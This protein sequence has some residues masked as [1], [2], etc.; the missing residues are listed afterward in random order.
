MNQLTEIEIVK[1]ILTHKEEVLDLISDLD[2]SFFS[3]PPVKVIIYLL[4]KYV[5]KFNKFPN[6][7]ELKIFLQDNISE[8]DLPIDEIQRKIELQKIDSILDFLNKPKEELVEKVLNLDQLKQTLEKLVKRSLLIRNIENLKEIISTGEKVEETLESLQKKIEKHTFAIDEGKTIDWFLSLEK[9]I[10]KNLRKSGF[11]FLD[12]YMQ[13]GLGA[14][15]LAAVASP[16]GIGKT[17]FLCNLMYNY[18]ILYENTPVIYITLELEEPQIFAR[19]LCIYFEIPFAAFSEKSPKEILEEMIKYKNIDIQ[20]VKRT[21]QNTYVKY[22]PSETYIQEITKYLKAFCKNKKENPIVIID[23]L[24]KIEFPYIKESWTKREK[25]MSELGNIAKEL[26]IPIWIACQAHPS[27]KRSKS[28]EDVKVFDERDIYG[29]KV[30]TAQELSFG[31]GLVY[32]KETNLVYISFF[33]NRLLGKVNDIAT[34][35]YDRK[36]NKLRMT[37]KEDLS[38]IDIDEIDFDLK[39]ENIKNEKKDIDDLIPF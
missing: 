11:L 6:Y 37:E 17:T 30:A 38:T 16:P 1:S 18:I 13:G 31:V 14:G 22:F 20:E 34:L 23:F 25:I 15:E 39:E 33:K 19:L 32:D 9:P 27:G 10:R 28:K 7:T 36:T 2:Y 12:T 4:N 21:F 26:E 35:I 8:I 24:N 5:K 3:Y 29:G